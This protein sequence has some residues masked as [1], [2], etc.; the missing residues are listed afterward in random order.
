M[1]NF[2]HIPTPLPLCNLDSSNNSHHYTIPS[3]KRLPSVTTMINKT[4]SEESKIGLKKWRERVGEPVANYIFSEAATIGTET[5]KLNENYINM[6]QNEDNFHL[7]SHAHHMNFRPL[8]D[9]ITK[10]YGVEARLFSEK[11]GLAGTC[12]L[13]VE[14]EGKL[15]ILDYKTKRSVQTEEWM[16]DYFIQTT[17]YSVMWNESL[18]LK[19]E[20]LIILVSSEKNTIQE[21]ISTPVNYLN[22]LNSRLIQFNNL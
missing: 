8:L 10:V 6:I 22:A 21:F 20:Q 4:K 11:L 9:K 7:L 13:I 17:A 18:D 3:G 19:I 16:H 5:H 1:N 14:Y 2:K 15:S 12:D